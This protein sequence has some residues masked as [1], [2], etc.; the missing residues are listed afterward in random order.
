MQA[1]NKHHNHL[2]YTGHRTEG[3]W[4]G[5]RGSTC[6]SEG[7]GEAGERNKHTP[8]LTSGKCSCIKS[9][10]RTHS[11]VAMVKYRYCLVS[12]KDSIEAALQHQQ[13]RFFTTAILMV[14]LL[15]MWNEENRSWGKQNRLLISSY[16][17][18]LG[19]FLSGLLRNKQP[20]QVLITIVEEPP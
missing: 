18:W 2:S 4:A 14:I 3:K 6:T 1:L 17:V 10:D 16:R 12:P 15:E 7:W 13:A 8:T 11:K 9:A 20:N 19:W 5:H